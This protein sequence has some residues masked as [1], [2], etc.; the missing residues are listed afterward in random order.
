[1]DF[2]EDDRYAEYRAEARRWAGENIDPALA[3]RM[4]GSGNHH[5]WDLH[6][7]LA[8]D[9]ILGAGWPGEY[10]G[11]DVPDGLA[12][13]IFQEILGAG[14]LLDG[15]MTTDM[16]SRTIL[17]VGSEEQKRSIIGAALRGEILIVLGY[18]EPGSGSDA[19]AAKLRAI[20]DGDEWVL[21]GS[22]MFTSTAHEATHVFLLSRSNTDVPKHRGL[23]MFLAPLDSPGVDIQP[24]FTLGG[25][26]TNATFYADV[27]VPDGARIGD[28]DGGWDV[29]RVALVYERGLGGPPAG[30]TFTEEV[31]A[32]ARATERP[33][34]SVVFDDAVLRDRLAR[35]AIDDEVSRLLSLRVAW[36]NDAGR[37]PGVEGVVSKLFSTEAAQRAKADLLDLIGETALLKSGNPNAPMGGLVAERFRTSVVTTIYGG[38]SE[39]MRDIIAERRLQ[40]PRNRPTR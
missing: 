10:G 19:A 5:D 3:E 26:R 21:N 1:M 24:V 16:I 35:M 4:H 13:A 2:T 34:G 31:A 9:G 8:V 12:T 23:T 40:L 27:R 18:T 25:Q 17:H 14:V 29:M 33:D 36:M 38:A 20:R 32:W 39:I 30:R 22:K 11:T 37:M 15:W 28:V 6:R 7:R